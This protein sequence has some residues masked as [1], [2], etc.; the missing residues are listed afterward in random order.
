MG[1]GILFLHEIRVYILAWWIVYTP[2]HSAT[3]LYRI[4]FI[5]VRLVI[6]DALLLSC[7]VS[8]PQW[9]LGADLNTF[10]PDTSRMRTRVFSRS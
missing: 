1:I 9:I 5:L 8:Y 2:L 4:C 3:Q 7:A 6:A 10:K